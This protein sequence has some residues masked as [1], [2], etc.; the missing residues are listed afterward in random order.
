MSV[1]SGPS[2]LD[3]HPPHAEHQA[4]PGIT[5]SGQ[6]WDDH[7]QR[8]MTDTR[9]NSGRLAATQASDVVQISVGQRMMSA[10][11][12]SILTSLLVTP[13]DVVR[14]RLQSQTSSIN[15]TS[16]FT[17]HTM[18]AFKELPANIGV[19]ACCREVFWVGNTPEMCLVGNGVVSRSATTA[20]IDCAVEETRQKTF[21]ST[22]DG[23]RK[24]ARNEGF[25]TLWRGLSPTLLM[26]V[27]GN[28]IYLAGYEWLRGDPQSPL[29]RIVGD[30]YV[31]LVAGSIAR[32]AAASAISPIEMFRTRLQ[33]T[34]GTGTD[35]FRNTLQSLRQMTVTRGYSSLWR[36]FTL[37]MW[38][39]VP[40]SGLYWWG[41]EAMRN[42][43]TD[44]REM[45]RNGRHS[46]EARETRS[47]RFS[48]QSSTT[49]FIDS[50][51]AGSV[52]GAAAALVTTP[53]DVGKTRQQVFRHSG[54]EIAAAAATGAKT[55]ASELRPEQLSMPR[56]LLHIF[57][58]E[59][60]GGLFKG[61]VARCMKVAPGCAIMISSYEIGKK[62]A[63][64]VN[65]RKIHDGDGL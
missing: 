27:P 8:A 6:E 15:N 39:D 20:A 28:V 51:I 30:N 44:V 17:A 63:Q 58:H 13:L 43:L 14:V 9:L 3:A 7:E 65:N 31:P 12:G 61:W 59:G 18:P 53:F 64:G 4:Y 25:T 50:F 33:A 5:L 29:P 22:F 11:W 60:V 45:G 38:R 37:T 47:R 52:S 62:M 49:T 2:R 21:T 26:A 10:T 42:V 46:E 41:Y 57:R 40:F 1:L 35:H 32:I 56:F 36:G 23:M 16:K 34:P 54:D 19:T 24:I 55:L 48:N